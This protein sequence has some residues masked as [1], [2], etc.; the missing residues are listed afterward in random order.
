MKRGKTQIKEKG[1]E[2]LRQKNIEK[3]RKKELFF[4]PWSHLIVVL[5]GLPP[6]SLLVIHLTHSL[7]DTRVCRDQRNQLEEPALYNGEIR[8]YLF[9]TITH[10]FR[11]HRLALTY[12]YYILGMNAF[13]AKW[14]FQYF[15][16]V[17]D[18]RKTLHYVQCPSCTS[19][20]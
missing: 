13:R 19:H 3:T 11:L 12:T 4:Q 9:T 6:V 14:A 7:Q 18:S 2:N 20:K 8:T 17:L 1:K 5:V 15:A 10:L 16:R